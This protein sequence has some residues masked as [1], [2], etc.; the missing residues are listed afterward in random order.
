MSAL[1]LKG[2]VAVNDQIEKWEKILAET[3]AAYE[4]EKAQMVAET[5]GL[6]ILLRIAKE[7]T[8]RTHAEALKQHKEAEVH[9]AAL[10]SD[11]KSQLLNSA[12]C[13]LRGGVNAEIKVWMVHLVHTWRHFA[14]RSA[15]EEARQDTAQK[16]IEELEMIE[17]SH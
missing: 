7:A 9:C 11:S 17:L 3:T 1:E 8:T 2:K 14:L 4:K 13:T 5:V 16:S 6:E 12:L 10:M 15:E